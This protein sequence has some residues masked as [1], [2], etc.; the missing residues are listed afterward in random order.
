MRKF[1]LLAAAAVAAVVVAQGG[2]LGSLDKHVKTLFEAQSLSANMTYQRIGG[3]PSAIKV[4][5]AKPAMV[6]IDRGNELIVADGNTITVLD[7]KA[8]SYYKAPQS[9]SEIAKYFSEDELNL[10]AAFFDANAYSKFAKVADAGTKNRKG[11]TLN[12]V[13]A[14][15]DQR[16]FKKATYYVDPAS[17]LARQVE[18]VF[19]DGPQPVR[20]L[21][22]TKEISV[23]TEAN[24][25]LF[26]FKA[27]EG[28]KEL[29]LEEMASDKWY[30]D[31][32]E[33]KS[34]AS[35]TGRK[36]FVDFFAT[37]CGPCKALAAEVF[38][39]PEFKS[40]SK[41]MVF[42]KIDVD[43]QK[44]VAQQYGITAMPTQMVLNAD[45]SVIGK[46]IGYGGVEDFFS[47]IN[48]YK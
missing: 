11:T 41:S 27:P 4:D 28:S 29:S 25:S 42:L 36:I 10:L 46:K 48:A 38:P 6:R 18:Y 2:S 26:A 21:L 35:K 32:E 19:T 37:W 33:A 9:P 30:Y 40:L 45:G 17:G 3:T 31:L 39:L 20:M 1:A 15:V 8:N 22:D 34:V 47:F 7:K 24:A 13:E 23:G 44:S 43:A 16:G 5:L 14:Q 12:V